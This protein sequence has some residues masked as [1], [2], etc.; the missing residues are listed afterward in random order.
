MASQSGTIPILSESYVEEQLASRFSRVRQSERERGEIYLANHSLG[1]P[2][3]RMA[4]DVQAALDLWYRQMDGAWTDWMGEISH[5]RRNVAQLIGLE[6]AD[7]VAPKTSAGQGL[8]AVLNSFPQERPVRVLATSGEF[9]SVD[10]ILKTYAAKGRASVQ[11]IK[12][13]G[14][15]GPVPTFSADAI[16]AELDRGID[17]VA[18][19]LVFFGTGQVLGS[20]E[21]I[22][23]AAH[24]AGALV[25]LDLYHAAGV[26]PIS[27]KDLRADFAIGG[28]YKYTRGGPGACWLAFQPDHVERR[29]L[30]TGWFAKRDV[31]SYR[32]PEEPEYAEGGDSWLESTPPILPIYQAKSGLELT[33]ELGVQAIRDYNLERLRILRERFLTHGVPIFA[34]ERE[35][36]W[37][38]FALLPAADAPGLSRKLKEAGV[39]TDARGGFVRF[40]PDLL[41]TEAELDEAARIVAACLK[42]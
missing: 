24:R 5:F 36:Q 34:P 32:R 15:E 35:E 26:L 13:S 9:D 22:V 29:T 39:N 25:L 10:F 2:L 8:R 28:S 17:L 23:E 31:F 12:P 19:S 16:I 41:T 42:P 30:D 3:D 40:G 14:W 37:G 1:R 20:M 33:L 6:R 21:E 4:E 38:A 18:L 7:C 27:L 11:W